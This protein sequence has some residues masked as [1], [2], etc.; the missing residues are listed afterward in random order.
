MSTSYR[1]AFTSDFRNASLARKSIASFASVCG[2]TEAELADI[3]LAAGEALGNAVE[4]GRSA[5][6]SGF[7]VRCTFADDELIIEIRDNG[8][9][10]SAILSDAAP[11]PGRQRGLGI[12][13]M[14]QLMDQV[15]Y[16]H[17]GTLVRMARK[18]HVE[19][20]EQRA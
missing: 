13:L 20:L 18:R 1:A 2:F 14:R 9:G 11:P 4:H 15:T 16:A 6:S 7:S 12:F 10:F 5:R 8:H 19:A 17:N 3:R